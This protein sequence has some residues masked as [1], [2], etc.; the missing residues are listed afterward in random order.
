MRKVAHIALFLLVSALPTEAQKYFVSFSDKNNNSYSIETPEDFLSQRAIDRRTKHD[1]QV[2]EQDLPVT[3]LYVDS[4]KKMGIR[5]LWPSKWLNGVLVESSNQPLMDT[6]TRVSFISDSK[7]VYQP[8]IGVAARKFV[9]TKDVE[10]SDLKS[11]SVYG[12]SWDQT[13]TLNGHYLHQNN[14][15]GQDIEI[16]VID[17]GFDQVNT[18]PLFTHLWNDDRILTYRDFIKPG[19]NVF[20]SDSHGTKVLSVIGG[21]LNGE[22]KGSAPE[23]KFHLLRTEDNAS[24]TPIEEYNWVVAAEYADSIGADVINTSLGYYTFIGDYTDYTYQD[25]DGRTTIVVQGAETA[26]SKGMVVVCSAGNEGNNTWGKIISPADGANVLSVAAMDS[27]SLRA[28]FSSYGYSADGRVKPDVAAIGLGTAL[29]GTDGSI[30]FLN[31]TSFSAPVIAGFTACL[32]QAF[33]ELSNAEII[34]LVKESCNNYSIP[35]NSFGYGIPDY[36][37]AM[38]INN[39]IGNVSKNSIFTFPN[40]FNDQLYISCSEGKVSADYLLIY[41]IAGNLVYEDVQLKLPSS[42]DGLGKLPKGIYLLNIKVGR[43]VMVNKLVKK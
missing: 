19:G 16:A 9:E 43:K 32:W 21:Y 36:K 35:D 13:Q 22:F 18:L 42:I 6:I 38:D 11:S 12:A 10:P 8:T 41:D 37:K 2:L 25:M 27:D 7:M 31:G 40:P 26:F 23:A 39:G 1:I 29:Q 17:N 15:E 3:S 5:V 28:S 30:E 14:F 24:E 4:V 34:Q 33:P 20:E